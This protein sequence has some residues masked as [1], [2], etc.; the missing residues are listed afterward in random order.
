MSEEIKTSAETKSLKAEVLDKM[1][2]LATAGFGLE[3]ALGSNDAIKSLFSIIFPQ[4]GN[5][6]TQLV[7]AVIITALVVFITMKLGKL[8]DLAKK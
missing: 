3:A 1:T 5:V 2:D 6:I 7:Y 4:D 8:T